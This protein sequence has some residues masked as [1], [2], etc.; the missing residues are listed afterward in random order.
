MCSHHHQ[1]ITGKVH[2]GYLPGKE[3]KVVGLSKLNRVIEHFGRRGAIQEQ[4]TMGIHKAVS[5]IIKGNGGVAVM[6]EATHNCVKCRGVKHDG[7]VM[8][9]S[10]LTGAF[11]E[12]EA[13][14]AEFYEFIKG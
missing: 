14:R 5:T 2:V 3:A 1:T 10:K 11:K 13:T 9:T 12:D 7:A 6:I 4:L 8:R